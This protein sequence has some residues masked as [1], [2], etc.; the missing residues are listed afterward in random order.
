MLRTREN[1]KNSLTGEVNSIFNVKPLNIL[2]L[3]NLLVR[4]SFYDTC[5]LINLFVKIYI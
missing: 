4:L 1:M 2:Y 3:L 5:T